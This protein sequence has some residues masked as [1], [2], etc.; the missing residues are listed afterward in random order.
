MKK[1]KQQFVKE[2]IL[3]AEED[4]KSAGYLTQTKLFNNACFHSQQAVEKYFKGWLTHKEIKF[5]KT[6]DLAQLL[7]LLRK[8]GEKIN[9]DIR[10]IKWLSGC[11]FETRYPDAYF[12]FHT[13][14]DAEKAL[15]IAEKIIKK[16]KNKLK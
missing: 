2:W 5:T 16:V 9:I 8:N 3:F 11:Y 1:T 4:L 10:S 15:A 13:K 12:E 6:H 7:S 14:K